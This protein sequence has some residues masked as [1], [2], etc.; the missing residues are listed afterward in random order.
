MAADQNFAMGQFRYGFCLRHGRGLAVDLY[1]AARFWKLAADQNHAQAQFSYGFCLLGGS[2][3]RIDRSESVKYVGR[4]M[5]GCER[6]EGLGTSRMSGSLLD[7]PL[8]E[9]R[10]EAMYRRA[11]REGSSDMLNELGE[12]LEVGKH[13]GKDLVLASGGY[14]EAANESSEAQM[15]YGFCLEHGLGVERDVSKS[16]EFYEKSLGGNN[17]VGSGHYALSLHFGTGVWEDLE[18]AADHY[19]VVEERQRGFLRR[20]S[21]RCFRGLNRKRPIYLPVGSGQFELPP[22][23]VDYRVEAI[24]TRSAHSLGRGADGSVTRERNR[25]NGK[26][27]IA[28]KWMNGRLDDKKCLQEV[29]NLIAVR[30]PCVVEI[31]GWSWSSGTFE[32]QMKLAENGDLGQYIGRSWTPTAT[33]VI[34]CG[35]VLGMRYVHSRGIV[36]RDLKPSNILLDENWH[37]LIC[38]FGRSK[39]GSAE[40]LSTPDRG[41]WAY[42]APEQFGPGVAYNE[43]VDI[44]SFGLILYALISGVSAFQ[45][46]RPR[47]LP[48]VP[49]ECGPLI[50]ELI[51]RCC[52][53]NPSD[54]P[55]FGEIFCKFEEC[56]FR[57]LPGANSI[58]IA[59]YVREVLDLE[60]SQMGRKR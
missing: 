29:E 8:N 26:E 5:G 55:S 34:I 19:E 40:G 27:A 54:R 4:A 45:K 53:V 6:V 49:E 59:K 1:S 21:S 9:V 43:K 48:P 42:S 58:A 12:Y 33:S 13:M 47:V 31:L 44:Y 17:V 50:G 23:V 14:S 22:L 16:F 3:F 10:V 24:R 35:I 20:N 2:G 56:E 39:L 30:H 52:A 25:E 36:H 37:A 60:E 51:P 11:V 7:F 46:G 32:L 57:L 41:T 28:V 15:N 18:C 38:D